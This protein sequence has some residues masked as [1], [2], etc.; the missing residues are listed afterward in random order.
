MRDHST[1]MICSVQIC[2]S[3]SCDVGCHVFGNRQR[4]N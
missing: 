3:L 2:N 4:I 1:A